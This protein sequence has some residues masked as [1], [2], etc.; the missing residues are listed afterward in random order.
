LALKPKGGVLAHGM[1]LVTA[2]VC[3]PM[4][5]SDGPPCPPLPSP[6]LT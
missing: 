4:G 5:A 3:D 6:W 2:C 1:V